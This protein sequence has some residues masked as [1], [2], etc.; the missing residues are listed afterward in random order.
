MDIT[1]PIYW[2]IAQNYDSTI[3]PRYIQQRGI[4]IEANFRHLN[5]WSSSKISGAFLGNDKGGDDAEDVNPITGLHPHEGKNRYQFNLNHIGGAGGPWSTFV[6]YN[7]VS[8]ADYVRDLGNMTLDE[9]SKTHIQQRAYV[10]YETNHWNYQIASEDY[11]TVT[12][13]LMD[14]YSILPSA[15][16]DGYYRF[17]NN[18]VVNLS[19]QY[20]VF[21][22]TNPNKVEG[23][24]TRVDYSLAWD[25]R[26]DWG[27]FKPKVQLKHLAYKLNQKPTISPLVVNQNPEVTVPVFSVDSGIFFERDLN[28]LN[29]VTQTF[30]PRLMYLHSAYKDQSALPDFDTREFTPSYDLLFRDTR[31][32]GGDRIADDKRLTAG[33]TTRIIDS[34]SGQERFRA[35]IAQSAYYA[36]RRVMLSTTPTMQE[37]ADISRDRSVIA[38]ELA[39]R[40][41]NNWRFTSDLVY[42]DLD[43][44]LEKTGFSARYNDRKKRIFNFSYRYTRRAARE[45]D[46]QLVD[47]N[48]KQTN[49]SGFVPLT[50]TLN[51]VGRWNHDF[52]NNRELEIFAGFEYHNCCWR[53]SLFAY[54]SLRRDDDVFLPEDEL[55]ARNGF[56][57]KIEFKGLGGSGNRVD[58]MLHNGIYGYERNEN[59]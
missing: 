29:G 51:L 37:L 53:T 8:D 13:G 23:N 17:S 49:I 40:I 26:W 32:V 19:N 22:H 44:H 25:Q 54:R 34:K 12:R 7:K 3:S 27:F 50:P 9:T 48:I 1:Q 20:S 2:N 18:L 5:N 38:L 10:R 41:N 4:G 52:T 57:F 16:V 39:A 46:G 21:R 55:K 45:Y 36:D 56:A 58:T 11:Q 15:L 30:E 59:F 43:N 42:D 6:D 28:W 33:I 24:R 35:S 47:Q 31:F 14:Q